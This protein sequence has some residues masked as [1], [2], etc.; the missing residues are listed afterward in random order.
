V[1]QPAIIVT[2]GF[3]EASSLI[4]EAGRIRSLTD[5]AW[6]RQVNS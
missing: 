1:N 6:A 5:F 3:L 2:R 4:A